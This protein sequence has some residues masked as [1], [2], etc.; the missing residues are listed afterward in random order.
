MTLAGVVLAVIAL[1]GITVYAATVVVRHYQAAP[2]STQSPRTSG[3]PA[4]VPTKLATLMSLT[5]LGRTTA[6]GFTLTDQN[7]K[8]ISLSGLR[9]KV[10]VLEFL[11]SHCTDICP[12]VSNEFVDAYQDLG[13]AA[14]KVV[15]AGVNVN[16]YHR[17]V[18]DVAAFSQ[19]QNLTAIPDWHFFTGPVPRLRKVWHGYYIVVKAPSHNADIIH[20]SQIYFIDSQGRTRYVASPTVGHTK[21]GTAYLP[22]KQVAA[23]GRGIALVAQSLAQ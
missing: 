23:W 1:A 21:A 14:S 19:H 15:F 17:S 2:A 9:G 16:A 20:T 7:G 5:P 10:V 11:D 6:P 18:H 4:S 8:T 22:A 3:L 12:I 13:P